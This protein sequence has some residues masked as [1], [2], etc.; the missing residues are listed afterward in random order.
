MLISCFFDRL[1]EAVFITLSVQI[2][3]NVLYFFVP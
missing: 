3:Y 2:V 1:N